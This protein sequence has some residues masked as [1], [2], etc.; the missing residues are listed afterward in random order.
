MVPPTSDFLL[1]NT[2]EAASLRQ[3]LR[4]LLHSNDSVNLRTALELLQSGGL[5]E[6]LID[7]VMYAYLLSLELDIRERIQLL[8]LES[9]QV[10]DFSKRYFKTYLMEP[11]VGLSGSEQTIRRRLKKYFCRPQ[12]SFNPLEIAKI[13]Y[14]I[15]RQGYFYILEDGAP[16]DRLAFLQTVFVNGHLY[17]AGLSDLFRLPDELSE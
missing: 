13:L 3:N 15:H 5:P 7:D 12:L 2:D 4:N 14:Q 8:L 17:L 11:W 1:G 9:A 6:Q 10:S 16:K